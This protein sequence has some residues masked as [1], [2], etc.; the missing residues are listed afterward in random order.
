MRDNR[1]YYCYSTKS[2]EGL[3][4]VTCE[5]CDVT[6]THR[7]DAIRKQRGRSYVTCF[8]CE[9]KQ[10]ITAFNKVIPRSLRDLLMNGQPFDRPVTVH[11]G[12]DFV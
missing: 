6:S 8:A 1:N 10:Y 12:G 2:S 5:K 4:A 7:G 11:R 9:H 3:E